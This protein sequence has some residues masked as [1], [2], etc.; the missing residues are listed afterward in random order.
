M[1]LARKNR[2]NADLGI[3]RISGNIGW[4]V[5]GDNVMKETY[6][7]NDAE[8]DYIMNHTSEEEKDLLIV[9]DVMTF[10]HGRKIMEILNRCLGDLEEE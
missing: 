8:F 2:T 7:I 10:A 6:R 9:D 1:R 3:K 4:D 5:L